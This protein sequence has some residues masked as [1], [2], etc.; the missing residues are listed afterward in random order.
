MKISRQGCVSL[1]AAPLKNVTCANEKLTR[2][3]VVLFC[4]TITLNH[5]NWVS[6]QQG[7]DEALGCYVART[8]RLMELKTAAHG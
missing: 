5:H 1:F 8:R 4:A 7:E 6:S 3:H 2:Q